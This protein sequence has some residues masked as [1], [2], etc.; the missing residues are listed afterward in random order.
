MQILSDIKDAAA[1]RS[2][3]EFVVRVPDLDFIPQTFEA[4][5]S[6][7]AHNMLAILIRVFL[8]SE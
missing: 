4:E 6:M 8:T 3:K 1:V 7:C 5:L 2:G